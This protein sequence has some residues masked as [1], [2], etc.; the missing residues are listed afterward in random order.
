M[1]EVWL[2]NLKFRPANKRNQLSI[3]HTASVSYESHPTSAVEPTLN[4]DP[5]A[6]EQS[7]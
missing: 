1:S 2:R 4:P 3:I 5:V 7:Y 6:E